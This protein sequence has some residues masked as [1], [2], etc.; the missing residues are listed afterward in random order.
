MNHKKDGYTPFHEWALLWS[1]RVEGVEL[2]LP[3]P[4]TDAD[5]KRAWDRLIKDRQTR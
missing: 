2:G 4:V 1:R 5:F 3:S